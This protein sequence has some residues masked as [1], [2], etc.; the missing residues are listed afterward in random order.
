MKLSDF[1]YTLPESLIAQ[2]PLACRDQSRLMLLI[3]DGENISH[4]RFQDILELLRPDDLLVI[5]NTRVIPGR[6]FGRKETGGNAE[7][8][9]LNYAQ[10][11]ARTNGSGPIRLQCLV[12]ASK[13]PRPGSAIHFDDALVATVIEKNDT[14]Y[15]LAFNCGS[16]FDNMLEKIGKIPLPPYIKRDEAAPMSLEDRQRYQTVYA[17]RKGAVAAPTAGLHFSTAL[18]KNL[19]ERGINTVAVTLHVGYGTFLPVRATEVT[20]HRMHPEAFEISPEAA[21]AINL[22]KSQGQRIIAIGTTVVRVLEYVARQNGKIKAQS[23]EC[24]LFIYPGFKFQ[25][26]DGL[27]TNFHLPKSTLL[28]LVSAFAGREFTLQAYKEAIEEQYRFYSYG[29]AMLIL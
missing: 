1:D 19:L 18:L 14:I 4:H 21:S 13:P 7:V 11:M 29:D 9:L 8:L 2:S 28:M 27:I 10:S 16:D 22:A 15:T 20:E 12:K 26:A 3:R 25:M 23:A 17:D 6:L 24:N 5:N